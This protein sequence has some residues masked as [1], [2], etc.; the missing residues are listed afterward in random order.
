MKTTT[1]SQNLMDGLFEEMNRVR[2]IIK[3][4]D[5]LPNGAGF[6]GSSLMKIDIQNAERAISNN[7]VIQM[8]KA[9]ESLKDIE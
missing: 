6:I 1:K 8:L 7:D 3:E 9:Y 5:S 2:D 4:Y